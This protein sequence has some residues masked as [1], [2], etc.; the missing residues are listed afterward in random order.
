ME[1]YNQ[2]PVLG[3][4]GKAGAGKTT[5]ARKLREKVEDADQKA[6]VDHLSFA[7][8]LYELADIRS[9]DGRDAKDRQLYAI[10]EVV[11][12]LLGGNP[13]FGAPPYDQLVELVQYIQSIP[14]FNTSKPREFILE[15]AKLLREYD[16]E[17]FIKEMRRKIISRYNMFAR[18][19]DDEL[20]MDPDKYLLVVSDVRYEH[21]AEFLRNFKYSA[22]IELDAPF[23][24][25]RKRSA[26]NGDTMEY[27]QVDDLENTHYNWR[28]KIDKVFDSTAPVPDLTM[29][30]IDYLKGLKYI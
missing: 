11:C 9:I 22:L 24:V 15:V 14:I 28:V 10:H 2:I 30:V 23:D 18:D 1:L 21:E 16:D 12:R 5:L 19:V 6:H 27:S 13:L 25:R 8:P 3:I 26:S 7:L 29:N 20:D 17:V 4:K